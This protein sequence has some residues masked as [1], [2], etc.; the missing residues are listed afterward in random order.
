MEKGKPSYT[1]G[2]NVSWCSH[3]GEQY[4][5]SLKKLKIELSYDPEI[6]LLGIYP[7]KTL[8]RKDTCTPVFIAT[9]FTIADSPTGSNPNVH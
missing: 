6:P 1:V 8:I 2:G 5:A 4:G 9:L 3:Y 7:G